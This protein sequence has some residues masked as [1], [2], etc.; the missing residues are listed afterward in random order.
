MK[1]GVS[2]I[3][4]RFSKANNKYMK[5]YDSSK[6][7]KSIVKLDVNNLHG[8]AMSQYLSYSGL[9]CLNKKS[10][11]IGYILEVDQE[12]LDELHELLHNDYVLA[13]VKLEISHDMLSWTA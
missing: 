10:I 12:Y 3:T 2:Y 4:K 1:G 11:P 9:K 5:C 8:W 6:E 7:S 13:R